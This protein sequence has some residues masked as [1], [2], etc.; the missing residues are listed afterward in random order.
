M[1]HTGTMVTVCRDD[2]F[3][4]MSYDPTLNPFE[5]E[6]EGED[7]EAP[8]LQKSSAHDTEPLAQNTKQSTACDK[9][10]ICFFLFKLFAQNVI[11]D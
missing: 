11:P 9:K 6:V 7:L 2:Y 3:R 4:Q 5:D 10:Y 1:L 8:L